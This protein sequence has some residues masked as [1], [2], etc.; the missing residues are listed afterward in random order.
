MYLRIHYYGNISTRYIWKMEKNAKNHFTH[1]L[2]QME[3]YCRHRC[4]SLYLPDIARTVRH[5]TAMVIEWGSI[6][7]IVAVA[8]CHLIILLQQFQIT[9]TKVYFVALQ[10]KSL[11]TISSFLT[12]F[13]NLFLVLLENIF[14]HACGRN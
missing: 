3:I 7:L 10:L 6:V 8:Y 12:W 14:L 2:Q 13:L 1:F 11:H 9:N 5:Q 4:F